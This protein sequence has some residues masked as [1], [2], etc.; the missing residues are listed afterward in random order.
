MPA[1]VWFPFLNFIFILFLLKGVNNFVQYKFSHLPAKER[2]T[3][4]ELAK[5]FLNHINY[6]HLETPSQQRQKSPAEDIAAYKVNYTRYIFYQVIINMANFH[7]V[8]TEMHAQ[9]NDESSETSDCSLI[10]WK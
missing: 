2:Q 6:W 1:E 9:N 8:F 3:I 4:I 10:V 5:M 7:W